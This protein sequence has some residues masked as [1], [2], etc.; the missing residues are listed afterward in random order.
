MGRSDLVRQDAD[1]GRPAKAPPPTRVRY[2]VLGAACLLALISYVYR[3]GFA[4][5]GTDLKHDFELGDREWG[6]LSAAFLVAYGAFEVPWGVLGDRF[7]GRPVLTLVALTSACLTGA[8]AL[9][10]VLP[11][12][13]GVPL[14]FLL[15]VR[16]LFGLFQ[17]GLFPTVSRVM[18]DWMPVAER[19][20]AQGLVWMTSR[21]GGFLAYFV[22]AALV[23]ALGG[24]PAALAAL[25]GLGLLWAAGFWPWFRNRPEDMPQVNAAERDRI[26]AGRRAPAAGAHRIPWGALLRS[27][28]VWALCLMY[29]CLGFSGNFFVTFLKTYLQDHRHVP[30]GQANWLSSLP[31]AC[32]LLAC[33]AGGYVSDAIIR[34]IGNRRWGRRLTGAIGQVGAGVAFLATVWV[35]DTLALG[36]LLCLTFFCN[37]LAMGPAWAACADIGERYAGT[38][39]GKMNMVGNLAGAA[40]ILLT[41]YLFQAGHPALVFVVLACV[42]WVGALCWLGVD[43]TRPVVVTE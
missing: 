32:G 7:G 39:G 35:Q 36:V 33:F 14:A 37:D 41:G 1:A 31:L 28:S 15:V 20:T 27:R 21:L 18:A 29:G 23:T 3:L 17:A 2:R 40:E 38:I 22:V 6:Y 42:Y 5:L 9:A 10:V 16:F 24:W 8:V 26:L 4:A 11:A 34:R 13:W 19:G 30:P 25:T 12:G 43:V